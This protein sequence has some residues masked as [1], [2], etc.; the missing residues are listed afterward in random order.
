MTVWAGRD[1]RL[2]DLHGPALSDMIKKQSFIMKAA[3]E[4]ALSALTRQLPSCADRAESPCH[5]FSADGP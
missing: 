2:A 5:R 4:A 3:P 1:A